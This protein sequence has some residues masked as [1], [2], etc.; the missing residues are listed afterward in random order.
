MRTYYKL[1]AVALVAATANNF[2]WFALTYWAYLTTRSVISTSILAGVWLVA[3]AVSG[4]WFGSIVDHNKKKHAMLASSAASAVFF[5]LGLGLFLSAPPGAFASAGSIWFWA[6]AVLLLSGTIM[7]SIYAIALPT[8]VAIVVPEDRRD[9][10]NGLFG[11]VMGVSFALT[12]VISGFALAFGGMNVVLIASI[13]ATAC[14]LVAL[15]LI[16][17]EEKAIVRTNET[18]KEK[19]DILGTIRAIRA[20]PGLFA[21][22]LFTTINNF[23]GG[24]FMALMDAYGLSLVSVE[25]WGLLWGFLSFGFIASGIYIAKKGL[26]KE[27]L[28]RLF[29]INLITWTVCVFFT[30]QPSIILLSVGIL[31]WIFLMPFVE[32]TEQTIFQK[33]VPVE[34][35]GRVFGFAHSVEQAASPITA[36]MI[37]PITQLVFIPFM[38]DGA[39]VELIGNWYGTGTGRGIGLVFSIAGILGLALTL[40]AMRSGA[41]KRLAERYRAS[42]PGTTPAAHEV[43]PDRPYDHDVKSKA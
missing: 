20:I 37:G 31:I 24:V 21:L 5:L 19:V 18:Q 33:V 35:L 40:V 27:P 36:F 26:G 4:I 22:I 3:A 39:G 25:T 14:V 29:R 28:R 11:T 38:T 17:V 30:V 43:I 42:A 8:L 15:S 6:F 7:G 9:R 2:V 12:S 32:A 34:R 41:Y 1:L 13:I 16:R 10:A 23:L